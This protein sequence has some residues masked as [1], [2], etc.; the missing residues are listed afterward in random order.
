[1]SL[2]ELRNVCFGYGRKKILENIN[3]TIEPKDYIL[4]V[5]E[6]GSGKTS[7]LKCILG[8]ISPTKGVIRG[9]REYTSKIGYIP[10]LKEIEVNFPASV[11]EIVLSGRIGYKGKNIRYSYLDKNHVI[12]NAEKLKILNLLETPYKNLSGGQ[13]QRVLLARAM[14][15]KDEILILDEP[16]TGLGRWLYECEL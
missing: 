15:A 13:K 11:Y 12:E 1:M 4:I 3:L 8:E 16:T 10:Q 6:N 14:C 2:I 9:A 5:G 7:L